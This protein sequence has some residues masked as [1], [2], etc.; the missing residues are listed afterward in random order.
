MQCFKK[1]Y[2]L[3]MDKIGY[4]LNLKSVTIFMYGII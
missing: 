1:N 4:L 2:M 3:A